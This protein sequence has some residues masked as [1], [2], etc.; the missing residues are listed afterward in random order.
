MTEH[1]KTK[2]LVKILIGAAWIDGVIQPEERNYLRQTAQQHNLQD[3]PELKILLSELKPVTPQECYQWL[4]DYLG[5]NH[6][7]EDY[8]QLLESLSGL[9][10]SD[11]DIQTQE[12]KLLTTLQ[13]LDPAQEIPKKPLEKLLGKIQI[14]YRKA[15]SQQI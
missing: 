10:Y 15:I 14:L 3:E 9:L 12:A 11:G 1:Q 4:E 13:E 6:S 7:E 5:E 2:Q 8:Q